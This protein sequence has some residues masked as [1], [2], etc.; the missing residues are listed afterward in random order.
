M[1]RIQNFFKDDLSITKEPFL[2]SILKAVIFTVLIAITFTWNFDTSKNPIW[3]PISLISIILIII[4]MHFCGLKFFKLKPLRLKDLL[5]VVGAY[6]FTYGLNNLY[7]YLVDFNNVNEAG[8]G[9]EYATV[10][11]LASAIALALMPA[12]AEEL[13]FRGMIMRVLFRNHLFIGMIVSSVIFAALHQAD[14]LIGYLPYFYSAIILSLVYLKTKRI[15]AAM[16][17]HFIN[18]FIS[19]LTL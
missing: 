14:S 12:I 19:V 18:N 16:L 9:N 1:K 8:L 5:I 17:M 2:L 15:E 6:L 11:F 7:E 10:P 3:A 4:L 13:V